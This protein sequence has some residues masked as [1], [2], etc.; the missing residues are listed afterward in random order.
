M[1]IPFTLTRKR[2]AVILAPKGITALHIFNILRS[3]NFSAPKRLVKFYCSELY[4]VFF[5]LWVNQALLSICVKVITFNF[6]IFN[7]LA[8]TATSFIFQYNYNWVIYISRRL[9]TFAIIQCGVKW[10]LSQ[11][12]SLIRVLNYSNFLNF[13]F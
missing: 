11:V 1:K 4:K 13:D 7:W 12:S 8:A 2:K 9:G 10:T 6:I 3:F 5:S